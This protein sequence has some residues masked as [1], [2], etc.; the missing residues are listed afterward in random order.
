MSSEYNDLDSSDPQDQVVNHHQRE[1]RNLN[2]FVAET[3]LFQLACA[4]EHE[5][6]D[7]IGKQK[8]FF[9]ESLPLLIA[10]TLGNESDGRRRRKGTLLLIT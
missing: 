3:S 5:G 1:G 8:F 9:N 6:K 10:S 7:T 2:G 4:L